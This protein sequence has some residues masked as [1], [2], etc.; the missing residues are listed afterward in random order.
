MRV[1]NRIALFALAVCTLAALPGYADDSPSAHLVGYRCEVL[2][3]GETTPGIPGSTVPTCQIVD[4]GNPTGTSRR[5]SADPDTPTPTLD[6]LLNLLTRRDTT[7]HDA[8]LQRQRKVVR[9]PIP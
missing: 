3:V 4:D 1:T 8:A 9:R 7:R 5:R 2:N 6:S